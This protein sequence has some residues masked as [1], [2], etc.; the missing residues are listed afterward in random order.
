MRLI[1]RERESM[2]SDLNVSGGIVL[3]GSHPNC[4]VYLPDG[5]LGPRHAI[6]E[7]EGQGWTVRPL[8]TG[9]PT[10]VN[11]TLLHSRCRLKTGDEIGFGDYSIRVYPDQSAGG[12]SPITPVSRLEDTMVPTRWPVPA[13]A[14]ILRSSEPVALEAAA[15]TA[16]GQANCRLYRLDQPQDLLQAVA[17]HLLAAVKADRAWVCLATDPQHDPHLTAAAS[18]ADRPFREPEQTGMLIYRSVQRHQAILLPADPD[19]YASAMVA[20]LLAGPMSLGLA[21]VE[22]APGKPV[23][24]KNDLAI[25][26][27]TGS[28]AGVRLDE[29][30]RDQHV[31]QRRQVNQQMEWAHQI[32]QRLTP[33][34]LPAWENMEVAAWRKAGRIC[35][36]DIYDIIRLPKGTAAIV[37]GHALTGGAESAIVMAEVR[38]GFRVALLHADAPHFVLKE[39]NWLVHESVGQQAMRCFTGLLDPD[40]GRLRY[41]I[42]GPQGAYR[43]SRDGEATDLVAAEMPEIGAQPQMEYNLEEVQLAPGESLLLFT[44]GLLTAANPAGEPFGLDR[45][46]TGMEDVPNKSAHVMLQVLVDDLALHLGD[47]MPDEDITILILRRMV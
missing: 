15:L 42:A 25:L 24:R 16:L 46:L 13:D 23:F 40:S 43:I 30:L 37:L 8:D 9:T 4:D 32:Q 12:E 38:A 19:R 35:C 41:S 1:I 39:L 7:P 47:A 27:A 33:A 10:T 22:R 45:V 31:V 20:P 3:I 34:V 18:A 5:R 44:R 2:V 36:G 11:N 21:Y 29:L 6:L 26:R 28:Q 17:D 14:V